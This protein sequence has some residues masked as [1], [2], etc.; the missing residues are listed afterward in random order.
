MPIRYSINKDAGMI[1]S[2]HIGEIA[3]EEFLATYGALRQEPEF[4]QQFSMLID[5]RSARSAVRTPAALKALAELA[6]QTY[7]EEG[8]STRTAIVASEDVS[9]GLGRMYQTLCSELPADVG[10]FRHLDE[11]IKWLE[12]PADQIGEMLSDLSPSD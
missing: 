12:A 8:K 9:F 3:D 5:L 11:A 2:V 7:D 1:V 10:V 4:S 6:K